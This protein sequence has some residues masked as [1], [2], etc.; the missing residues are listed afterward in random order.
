MKKKS[1]LSL[2]RY[3]IESVQSNELV[4]H[5]K[6]FLI[7]SI[8]PDCIPSF[9]TRRHT[10]EE[11]F[12]IFKEELTKIIED[13]DWSQGITSEFSRRL[14]I[15]THYLADYFTFPHNKT[16]T[17]TMRE[18]INYEIKLMKY[19]KGFLHSKEVEKVRK[20]AISDIYYDTVDSICEFI[21]EVHDEYL[22]VVKNIYVDCQYIV[23]MTSHV[24]GSIMQMLEV[25]YAS[26]Q[27]KIA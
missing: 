19:L 9:I 14:G 10:V 2:S 17:G 18:H 11:T 3:L 21:K 26:S 6:A 13:Y 24:V 16:Y 25:D 7:G 15:I 5:R 20:H 27:V 22:K 8:L 12:D 1:H 4:K 23:Q